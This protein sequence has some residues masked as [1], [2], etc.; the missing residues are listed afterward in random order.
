METMTASESGGGS[1]DMT[2]TSIEVDRSVWRRVRSDAVADGK[3]VSEK[4][5][6][7]LEDYYDLD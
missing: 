6:E 5:E 4:L 1:D 3:N 2:H 7:V